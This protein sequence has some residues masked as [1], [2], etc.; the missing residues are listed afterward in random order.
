MNNYKPL[1]E[2]EFYY[3]E[4]PYSSIRL[5]DLAKGENYQRKEDD[6]IK[7]AKGILLVFAINDLDSFNKI[8]EIYS[9]IKK[10]RKKKYLFFC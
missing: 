4:S 10:K 7:K 9:D 2:D 6:Y 5:V 8:K 3:C 1:V